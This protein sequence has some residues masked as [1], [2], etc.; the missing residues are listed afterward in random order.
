MKLKKIHI[1][2]LIIAVL[3]LN[4][5]YFFDQIDKHERALLGQE[6]LNPVPYQ[7]WKY[8]LKTKNEYEKMITYYS[9]NNFK[10]IN[11]VRD[12]NLNAISSSNNKD[13]K[14]TLNS[15]VSKNHQPFDMSKTAQ[16]NYLN[17][18]PSEYKVWQ[19]IVF[20]L[21]EKKPKSIPTPSNP[22]KPIIQQEI[23]SLYRYLILLDSVLLIS[24]LS[25]LT[26]YKDKGNLTIE[27]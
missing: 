17:S 7:D 12:Y 14:S 27:K 11:S 23:N 15:F 21:N 9:E 10:I 26:I 6:W 1:T 20:D 25:F 16:A 8:Y 13:M 22:P 3:T 2:F 19:S 4:S 24:L 5:A 18:N